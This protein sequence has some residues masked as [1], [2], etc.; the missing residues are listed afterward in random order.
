MCRFK[1]AGPGQ[2]AFPQRRYQ[3]AAAVRLLRPW[4]GGRAK[5]RPR[6]ALD[7]YRHERIAGKDRPDKQVKEIQMQIA[8]SA[9][10]TTPEADVDP[11]FGRCQYFVIID[12]ETMRFE[13]VE[14]AGAMG[15][16]GAGIATAQMIASKGISVVITGNCGP[17][18]YQV[19]NAAGV[20]VITGVSG[21]IQDALKAYQAGQL[22]TAGQ[23]NVADHFGMG[24]G[25]GAGRRGKGI[26]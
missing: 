24:G 3:L 13:G 16:G 2:S 12:P 18:A 4:L 21:N 1:P 15:S 8:V 23:P 10:G 11:R 9:T 22:S 26:A 20:E 6:P 5:P 14:N 7:E 19:L 25:G 17:N